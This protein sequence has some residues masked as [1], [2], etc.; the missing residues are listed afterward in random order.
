MSQIK[1]PLYN[2]RKKKSETKE[3]TTTPSKVE[4][5]TQMD[6]NENNK[7]DSE[8][9][10][11]ESN[12]EDNRNSDEQKEEKLKIQ[13]EKL[14][15]DYMGQPYIIHE[16]ECLCF[17]RVQRVL[18]HDS[19]PNK[20]KVFQPVDKTGNA[21][22][23]IYACESC[24]RKWLVKDVDDY[25]PIKWDEKPYYTRK[26][27]E[28]NIPDEI[29]NLLKDLKCD[30]YVYAHIYFVL[31]NQIWGSR[32]PLAANKIK[33]AKNRDEIRFKIL[34]IKGIGSF[35]I[36]EIPVSTIADFSDY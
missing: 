13:D 1:P 2:P 10:R 26:F 28:R 6:Q 19:R 5:I 29:V 34:I 12:N 22:E 3:E 36:K 14:D 8:I 18:A 15:K 7:N 21:V 25:E 17:D 33:S 31:N 20:F 23:N 9:N 24:G 27:L 30:L 11:Q 35:E 4:E 16:I 32:V